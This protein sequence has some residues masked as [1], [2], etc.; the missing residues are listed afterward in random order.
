MSAAPARPRALR[1]SPAALRQKVEQQ[2]DKHRNGTAY[3]V[4][5][6]RAEPTPLPDPIL[7]LADGRKARV[8]P[9]VSPLAVWEQVVAKPGDEIL[10]L[11]T[12][13][14]E[15]D[16]GSGVLSRIFRQRIITVEPWDLVLNAFGAQYLDATLEVESWAGEALLDAMPAEGWPKLA[17]A[18][19]SR[20]VALRHLAAVRLGLERLNAGP[21]DLD[22][23][24]LLRWSALPGAIEAFNLLRT[25]EREGLARWLST[26]L[27]R[28]AR[29][30]FALIDAGHGADA[31]PLGLVCDALWTTEAADALRARGR[32]DSYFGD[33]NPDDQT[34][35]SFAEATVQVVS[36]MLTARD[37]DSRRQ[38]RAVLNRAEDLLV[39]FS[40]AGCAGHSK[41]LRAGFT[42]RLGT[43]A[44]ALLAAVNQPSAGA[45]ARLTTAVEALATHQLADDESER[46]RRVR[47]AYRLVRW[48]AADVTPP[49]SVADGINRQ[50]SEWG[51]VD[52]AL[53]Y[54]W[55]GEDVHPRLQAAFRT[56]YHQAYARR[57]E[58]DRAFAQR[59]AAWTA[60]GSGGDLLTV[61]NL[62]PRV[63][64]PLIKSGR[65]VLLVVLD[66]M[67]AA[68]AVE[69]AEELSQHWVEYDPLAGDGPARRR[70]V[71]A[72][73]PTLTAVSRTSL[74]AGALRSG[75][76]ETEKQIF[77]QDRWGKDAKVFHKGPAQG[78]AG[79]VFAAELKE[80]IAQR[81]RF[82]AVVI[83]TVDESLTYGREGDE[84]GWTASDIGYLR[85]LLDLA[86]SAG[87]AVIITSDHGHILDRE[88]ELVRVPHDASAR[89]R[90]GPEPPRDGE[91]ELTG[92]RV[93]APDNRIV[94]LWDPQLRYRQ[95]RA[96][97]HGGASLAEVTVPLLA[98]LMPNATD[99][100]KGWAA[101]GNLEPDWWRPA[102]AEPEPTRPPAPQAAVPKPRRK[103]AEAQEPALFDVPVDAAQPERAAPTGSLVAELLDTE[104]FAA[105]RTLMPRPLAIDKIRAALTALLDANNV[106]P[107]A[108]LAAR[109]G[110]SPARA[111]GFVVILQRIL[112]V[113]NYPVLSLEDGGRT[114]RL[115]VHLL[116]QQFGLTA[117]PGKSGAGS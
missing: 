21:D 102:Q 97:Y 71:V 20:D 28:P 100:P 57:R 68:V 52:R 90:L 109:A 117:D 54:V 55:A 73:L 10:V 69:I 72:A 112:N 85:S 6:V 35:R 113:D 96:G 77:D 53:T 25:A 29:A 40:A 87:R 11:L 64:E 63:V 60:A 45:I 81:D 15:S 79:E 23:S 9:C 50:I 84:A 36:E 41:I 80:A 67:S 94:A 34:I 105:Q 65:P 82:V 70:G 49:A 26:T 1:I 30:L 83:N 51:W 110:E 91:V 8:V 98:F 3:P 4:M 58:L 12:D 56:V 16:L 47:M 76:K 116:R 27:G 17:G 107:T 7:V 62:L 2:I 43:A 88:S 114:V 104:L 108:V 115:N 14:A 5:V 13:L 103:V 78:G 101:L 99:I 86:G 33:L 75:T 24:L 18:V 95:A 92:P 19:L 74:L 106:L 22:V 44:D 42:E 93:I 111:T 46:V 38:R 61:E 32:V 66:G 59:L 89:H 37:T 39:Q 31:L 48:L